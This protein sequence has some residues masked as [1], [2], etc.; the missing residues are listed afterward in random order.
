MTEFRYHHSLQQV[1]YL[2]EKKPN[3]LKK[4]HFKPVLTITKRN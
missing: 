3:L 2:D 1:K 4:L